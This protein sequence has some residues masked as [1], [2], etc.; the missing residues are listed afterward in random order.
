M[1][2]A[3]A[4]AA[5]IANQLPRKPVAVVVLALAVAA[6]GSLADVHPS[7]EVSTGTIDDAYSYYSVPGWN[8]PFRLPVRALSGSMAHWWRLGNAARRYSETCGPITIA[9]PSL[10]MMSYA[11]GPEVRVIDLYGLADPFVARS[12]APPVQKPGHTRFEI[13]EAYL[14]ACGAINLLPD[15]TARLFNLDPTLRADAEAM[16]RNVRW[17]EPTEL[18][19]FQQI[20]LVLTGPL[21]SRD[22]WRAIPGYMFP[23][24]RRHQ[25]WPP[26][27]SPW[28]HLAL[29]AKLPPLPAA[30]RR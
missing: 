16:K 30:G 20:E 17:A 10:G 5:A 8:N 13:P 22:R 28:E 1:G 9:Y 3:Y 11:A 21:W 14:Q 29:P 23:E 6:A 26:S 18:Q 19:R 7:F 12:P 4:G 24:R 15:W 27:H 2:S 25:P